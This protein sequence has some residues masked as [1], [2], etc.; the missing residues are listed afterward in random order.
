MARALREQD[1]V[2]RLRT[3]CR[4]AGGQSRWAAIAGVAPQHVN[5][6]LRGRRPPGEVMLRCLGLERHVRYVP[7][8]PEAVELCDAAG[9]VLVRAQRVFA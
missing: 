8:Q 1:V 6:V 2:S 3:A 4:L 5:D 9:E 7:R